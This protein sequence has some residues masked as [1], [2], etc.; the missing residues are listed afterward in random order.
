MESEQE[1]IK[2]AFILMPFDTSFDGIYKDLIVPVLESVGYEISRADTFV[3][4]QN[5]L[6][7]IVTSIDKADLIVAELTT[8]NPN[9]FYELGIAHG[10]NKPTVLLTQSIE[11]VPFDLRS[12]RIIVYSTQY[13]EIKK[14]QEPLR[15]IATRAKG[16]SI[17]FSNPVSDFAPSLQMRESKDIQSDV[18]ENGDENKID[19]EIS[20]NYNFETEIK[21][22]LKEHREQIEK[23]V[24]ITNSTHQQITKQVILLDLAK[25]GS[26]DRKNQAAQKIE[27]DLDGQLIPTLSSKLNEFRSL[28]EPLVENTINLISAADTEVAENKKVMEAIASTM[29]E[30]QTAFS[31]SLVR[32]HSTL[33]SISQ[34]NGMSSGLNTSITRMGARISALIEELAVG[35]SYA[36]RMQN[37]INQQLELDREGIGNNTSA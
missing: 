26:A 14:L 37:L 18:K 19:K 10:L 33:D 35:E 4:Q 6:K 13:D 8:L 29:S 15:E 11:K 2:L 5:I 17:S 32:A 3:D 34:M 16:G 27:K 12:Y 24:E 1:K 25:K 9:V 31:K 30:F 28:W 36:A 23:I 20:R 7:D 21:R 22:V